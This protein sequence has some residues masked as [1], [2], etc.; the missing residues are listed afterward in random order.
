MKVTDESL[1]NKFWGTSEGYGNL[2]STPKTPG[3]S[4]PRT[5]QGRGREREQGENWDSYGF[6]GG[7]HSGSPEGDGQGTVLRP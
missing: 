6:V 5:I 2:I 4:E 1:R 7:G 3:R